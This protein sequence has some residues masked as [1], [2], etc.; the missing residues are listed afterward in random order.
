LLPWLRSW[1]DA[2]ARTL[3][4]RE[5]RATHS[6]EFIVDDLLRADTA[7]RA[8]AYSKFRSAGVMTAN[9]VRRLENMP[10]LADGDVLQNPFTTSGRA[11]A[12]DN[13]PAKDNAA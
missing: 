8:E 11:P 5:E 3:L 13:Q 2:Y 7:A 4:S 6:F 12:N 10:P 1:T 9:D